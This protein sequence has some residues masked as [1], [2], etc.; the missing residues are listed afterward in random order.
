MDCQSCNYP[1]DRDQ[2]IPKI[3][4]N[5]GHTLCTE[6]I[7]MQTDQQSANGSTTQTCKCLECGTEFLSENVSK[8]PINL[9]LLSISKQ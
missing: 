8:F 7:T 6:C 5:C 1:Y 9:A 3:L 2:H 4:I